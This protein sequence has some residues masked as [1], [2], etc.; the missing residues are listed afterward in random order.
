M[1]TGTPWT[2]RELSRGGVLLGSLLIGWHLGMIGLNILAAPSG[3]WL[4]PE[5]PAP[6]PPPAFAQDLVRLYEPPWLSWW[7]INPNYH[8]DS[9][10]P[11]LPGIYL[12][13]KVYDA[14]GQK[15]GEARLPDP[16]ANSW[17]QHRQEQL[18]RLLGQDEPVT[19]GEE[20]LAPRGQT[21]PQ[22]SYWEPAGPHRF[23]LRTVSEEL[24]PRGQPLLKPSALSLLAANAYARYLCRTY[25]GTRVEIERHSRQP[26]P[27][28]LL[29][30]PGELSAEIFAENVHLFG[31][32]PR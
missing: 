20:R 27:P 31:D 12:I 3:P 30:Q 26:I 2:T 6:A 7:K 10:R 5:G 21:L 1:P 14:Q 15:L 11:G 28:G 19:L 32:L 16:Q 17:V 9:N 22:V 25:D 8:F 4:G 24:V 29:L 18:A 23:Q 13:A